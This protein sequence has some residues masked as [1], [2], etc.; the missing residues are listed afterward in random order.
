[1]TANALPGTARHASRPAWTTTSPSRSAEISS[2]RHW[3]ACGRCPDDDHSGPAESDPGL[4][5]ALR[6]LRDLG[7]DEFVAEVV[8]AFAA[9]APTLLASL[10]DSLRR[11]D[12]EELRRAAHTLK[13]NG[14]TLGAA[15]FAE[16]C[17]V[18]ELRAKDGQL[19]GVAQLVDQIQQE[20]RTLQASL[21]PLGSGRAR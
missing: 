8:D 14:A 16:R 19:D 7:G 9:D 11:H 2:R 3:G 15:E 18:V 1:M 17:R 12:T 4:E 5:P 6:S 21:A 13:S 20:Y 10:E